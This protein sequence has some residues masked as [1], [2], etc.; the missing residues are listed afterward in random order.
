MSVAE[1][2]HGDPSADHGRD[3]CMQWDGPASQHLCLVLPTHTV[4][5]HI[6]AENH[7]SCPRCCMLQRCC[8][9]IP[10][11]ITADISAQICIALQANSCALDCQYI[12][13]KLTWVLI[14]HR[15]YDALPGC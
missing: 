8:M 15:M 9:A 3:P 13:C 10:L 4:H 7:L 2:V 11:Q 6:G 5:A 1:L 14:M 12:V